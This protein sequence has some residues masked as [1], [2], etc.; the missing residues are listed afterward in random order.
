MGEVHVDA[1][2]RALVERLNPVLPAQ[3]HIE[4]QGAEIEFFGFDGS[5][6]RTELDPGWFS[7]IGGS[8]WAPL[9]HL[10]EYVLSDVQDSVA[11]ATRGQA[12]PPS[13]HYPRDPLPEP[14]AQVRTGELH[15]GYTD[16]EIAFEPILLD[17]IAVTGSKPT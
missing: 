8:D 12:W 11:H 16:S 13:L 2:A 17:Q 10:T 3:T 1:L 15:F 14:W 5:Y 7:D 6:G 4:A 9:E